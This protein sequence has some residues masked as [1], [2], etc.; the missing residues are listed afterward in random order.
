MI[1]V[2]AAALQAAQLAPHLDFFSI[3]TNDLSQY[4]MAAERGNPAL[5]GLLEGRA[6]ARADPDRATSPPRRRRTA[7]GSASAASSPATRTSRRGWSRSAC[8]S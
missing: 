8:A 7:A 5:A 2:P 3:G 1:E 6:G 4:T